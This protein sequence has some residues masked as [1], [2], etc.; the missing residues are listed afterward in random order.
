MCNT[1]CLPMFVKL[2]FVLGPCRWFW[3]KMTRRWKWSFLSPFL[4]DVAVP[5]LETKIDV[6]TTSGVWLKWSFLSPWLVFR[7]HKNDHSKQPCKCYKRKRRVHSFRQSDHHLYIYNE[8]NSIIIAFYIKP[9][10]IMMRRQAQDAT[11][12]IKPLYTKRQTHVRSFSLDFRSRRRFVGL[13]WCG[14]LL[15]HRWNGAGD[16]WFERTAWTWWCAVG[17]WCGFTGAG[18]RVLCWRLKTRSSWLNSNPS[19]PTLLVCCC[20]TVLFHLPMS[21]FLLLDEPLFD[22][23]FTVGLLFADRA[24]FNWSIVTPWVDRRLALCRRDLALRSASLS[25]CGVGCWGGVCH[26]LNTVKL[27]D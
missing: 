11:K 1:E 24:S 6:N 18:G 3:M 7:V 12:A 15:A 21:S 17:R 27:D 19:K 4:L 8:P 13:S 20:N 22:E 5:K 25:F 10:I 2:T 9:S 14:G 16:C 23:P 26:D